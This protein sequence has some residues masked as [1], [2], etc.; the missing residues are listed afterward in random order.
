MTSSRGVRSYLEGGPELVIGAGD[1]RNP[2]THPGPLSDD[3]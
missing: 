1:E 3:R 2:V